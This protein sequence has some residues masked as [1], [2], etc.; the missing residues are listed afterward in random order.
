M[1]IPVSPP[2][3]PTP[4]RL[5][6]RGFGVD[7]KGLSRAFQTEAPVFPGNTL[8]CQ[9]FPTPSLANPHPS[10]L[11]QENSRE[12]LAEVASENPRSALTRSIS[13]DTSEEVGCRL[14]GQRVALGYRKAVPGPHLF[15]AH[16]PALEVTCYATFCPCDLASLGTAPRE[17][18]Y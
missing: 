15:L 17:P 18:P 11:C 3:R 12:A 6:Q 16:Q 10:S 8:P 1:S 9:D 5:R 7:G 4:G 2:P 14:G 13:S